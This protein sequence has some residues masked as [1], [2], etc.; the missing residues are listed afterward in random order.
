MAI[1]LT[2]SAR[3]P[4]QGSSTTGAANVVVEIEFDSRFSVIS[5]RFDTNDGRLS[6]DQ[7][8]ADAGA[9]G[10]AEYATIPADGWH[11]IS[12][13]RNPADGV[14]APLTKLFVTSTTASTRVEVL[15]EQA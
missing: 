3:L 9:L 5:V 2:A 6:L 15:G 1:D 14:V 4:A 7:T 10:S 13:R 12:V 8:L 11:S